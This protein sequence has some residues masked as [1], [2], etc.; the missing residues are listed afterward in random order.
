VVLPL[1]VDPFL[2]RERDWVEHPLTGLLAGDLWNEISQMSFEGK[3]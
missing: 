2:P 1:L 3:R